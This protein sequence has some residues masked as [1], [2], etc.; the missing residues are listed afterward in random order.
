MKRKDLTGIKFK[1]TNGK[2]C[3]I[4][5]GYQNSDIVYEECG[6]SDALLN[7]CCDAQIINNHLKGSYCVSYTV[8]KEEFFT[9][10]ETLS[11]ENKENADTIA[12]ALRKKYYKIP[13]VF[14]KLVG[15]VYLE[16]VRTM[17]DIINAHKFSSDNYDALKKDSLC[18]CFYCTSIFNPA[19][20]EGWLISPDGRKTAFCPHCGIDSVIGESS[21]Y[22][23]T[24][25]F[26][27]EMRK[28]WF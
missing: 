26:L 9:E 3:V 13:T 21:G 6:I 18:G 22:P 16:G 8:T 10:I 12:A 25:D 19:E 24:E 14:L 20:I 7:F 17:D 2:E 28:Y 15:E 5:S 4:L 23:I 27:E 1:S 11:E